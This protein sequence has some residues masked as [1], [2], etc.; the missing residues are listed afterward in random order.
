ME[1]LRTNKWLLMWVFAGAS[2]TGFQTLEVQAK[3][4]EKNIAVREVAIGFQTVHVGLEPK[5]IP[6]PFINS[7]GKCMNEVKKLRKEFH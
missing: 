7:C 2:G 6:K 4:K 1:Y 3:E 5:V